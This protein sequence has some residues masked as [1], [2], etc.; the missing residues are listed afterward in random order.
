MQLGGAGAVPNGLV[1]DASGHIYLTGYFHGSAS[2]AGAPIKSAGD[3]D[4]FLVSLASTGK[5]RW[6]QRL[7]G[8]KGDRG[9]GVAIAADGQIALASVIEGEVLLGSVKVRAPKWTGTVSHHVAADGVLKSAT[10][11]G[12]GT[13]WPRD[14]SISPDGTMWFVGDFRKTIV[15]DGKRVKGVGKEAF[16]LGLD[17]AGK[18]KTLVRLDGDG[19]DSAYAV[20][21]DASGNVYVTG[22]FGGTVQFGRK[23]YKGAGQGDLYVASYAPDGKPRWFVQYGDKHWDEGYGLTIDKA[24]N[25]YVTGRLKRSGTYHG[26]RS[27]AYDDVFLASLTSDGKERWAHRF[28]TRTG[29]GH[30][31]AIDGAGQL[32]LVGSMAG[33]IGFDSAGSDG[34]SG[35]VDPELRRMPGGGEPSSDAFVAC[36]TAAGKHRWSQAFGGFAAD[37]GYSLGIAPDG[38]VIV[39]GV[40]NGEAIFGDKTL[41]VPVEGGMFLACLPKQ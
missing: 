1:V 14:V 19:D 35:F 28:N 31:L 3:T 7:G 9:E 2:F 12:T 21:T 13:N 40:F 23:S 34:L 20:V 41:S 27:T 5:H 8:A 37:Y 38:A 33:G 32:C 10:G 17:A 16:V 11:F 25:V 24:G 26:G 22:G 36:F 4:A 6:S 39:A 15:V 29:E 18:A 30:D